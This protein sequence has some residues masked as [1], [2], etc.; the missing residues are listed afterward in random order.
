MAVTY[1]QIFT[2]NAL[3]DSFAT[4]SDTFYSNWYAEGASQPANYWYAPASNTVLVTYQEGLCTGLGVTLAGYTPNEETI[5]WQSLS[6]RRDELVGVRDDIHTLLE[7]LFVNEY[8]T[9]TPTSAQ[10]TELEGKWQVVCNPLSLTHTRSGVYASW[11]DFTTVYNATANSD[12]ASSW[13]SAC[14]AVN[15]TVLE[16]FTGDGVDE[17]FTGMLG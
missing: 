8:E 11:S 15:N 17:T 16:T 10:L 6:D 14:S 4:E 7:Q 3:S 13:A 12:W 1:K 2:K 9:S 5:T